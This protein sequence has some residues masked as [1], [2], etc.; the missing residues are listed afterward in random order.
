MG[1]KDIDFTQYPEFSKKYYLHGKS[2]SEIREFFSQRIIKFLESHEGIHI[3]CH[4]HR[5]LLYKKLDL[6]DPAEI[7]FLEKFAEE[8][9]QAV[10]ESIKQPVS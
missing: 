7:E 3:E 10:M 9:V 8:F 5:L 4:K 6:L 1:G 2:E